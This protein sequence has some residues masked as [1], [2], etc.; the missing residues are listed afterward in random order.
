MTQ[1]TAHLKKNRGAGRGEGGL[2]ERQKLDEH[3]FLAICEART[4]TYLTYSRPTDTFRNST[5][6]KLTSA[7]TVPPSRGRKGEGGR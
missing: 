3:Q 4:A 1:V 7:S 2:K 5:R 6:E